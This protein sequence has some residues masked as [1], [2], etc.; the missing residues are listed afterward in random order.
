MWGMLAWI[1]SAPPV[2]ALFILPYIFWRPG[3]LATIPVAF[4]YC[5][6]LYALTLLPLSKLLERREHA[7]LDAVTTQEE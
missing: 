7:I 3:L 5:I 6:G 2:L 1:I 4:V